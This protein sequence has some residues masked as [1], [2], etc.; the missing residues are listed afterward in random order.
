[1][2]RSDGLRVSYRYDALGR[3]VRRTSEHGDDQREH[4]F[5]WSGLTLLHEIERDVTTSWLSL[6]DELFMKLVGTASYGVLAHPYRAISELLTDDGTLAWQGDVDLSGTCERTVD[7]TAQPWRFQGHWEDPDTGLAHAWLRVYDPEVGGYLTPNPDG[8]ARGLNL[9]TYS[10]DPFSSTSA[11]GWGPE[12]DPWF[13]RELP[14]SLEAELAVHAMAALRHFQPS[15]PR[16]D[17][18]RCAFGA[19]DRWMPRLS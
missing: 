11:L 18:W 8:A 5:V 1:V 7:R 16:L 4:R 10:S 13:G 19:W 2:D 12:I 15:A 3:M 6:D 9:Y 17:P 14:L